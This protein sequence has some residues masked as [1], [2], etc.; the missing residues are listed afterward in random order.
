[1]TR[2][3]GVLSLLT[4]SFG[5]HMSGTQR[6]LSLLEDV[7]LRCILCALGRP[8]R[9]TFALTADSFRHVAKADVGSIALTV[10]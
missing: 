1:V 10:P 9:E 8:I 6:H 2:P 7:V 4:A 3:R 5:P